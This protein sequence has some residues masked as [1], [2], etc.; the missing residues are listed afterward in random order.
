MY[1]TNVRDL[2]PSKLCKTEHNKSAMLA[3]CLKL[4]FLK[5]RNIIPGTDRTVGPHSVHCCHQLVEV[6]LQLGE[7]GVH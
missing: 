5:L 3:K 1:D 4:L 7:V 6:Q 2:G